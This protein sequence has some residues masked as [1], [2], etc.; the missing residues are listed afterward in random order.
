LQ[1]RKLDIDVVSVPLKNVLQRRRDLAAFRAPL[2]QL[3]K[4]DR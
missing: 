2:A 4:D 1:K 3:V